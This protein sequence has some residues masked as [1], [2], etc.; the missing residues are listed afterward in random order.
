PL[1]THAISESTFER[2]YSGK[3]TPQNDAR[4]VLAHLFGRPITELLAEAPPTMRVAS[5]ETDNTRFTTTE[6]SAN[7]GADLRRME[8]Y[9]SM[10]ARRAI[11]F[12]MGAERNE[13]GEET[14]GY[15]Q[16][17]VRRIAQIY[18]RVPLGAILDDLVRIQDETFRLLESGRAK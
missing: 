2:W 17:E 3:V 4:R 7:L 1:A 15:L 11:E 12:A 18:V 16:D 9:A 6:E 10:A 8:R 14:M 5:R 13:V